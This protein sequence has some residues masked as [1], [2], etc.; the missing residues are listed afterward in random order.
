MKKITTFLTA[1]KNTTA[2]P[3]VITILAL[4]LSGVFSF[5]HASITFGDENIR[6][7]DDVFL[8]VE[9]TQVRFQKSLGSAANYIQGGEAL[10]SDCISDFEITSGFNAFS[11]PSL[12]DILK[13]FKDKLCN[14]ANDALNSGIKKI[15]NSL[16][17]PINSINTPIGE[18]GRIKENNLIKINAKKTEDKIVLKTSPEGIKVLE[19][20]NEKKEQPDFNGG[21]LRDDIPDANLIDNTIKEGQNTNSDTTT[22]IYD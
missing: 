19:R 22:L 2:L 5:S 14:Y 8:N 12:G 6:G 3:P 1:I 17:I 21:S 11:F 18:I 13:S 10:N 15:N 4:F 7:I 20:L 9:E 16:L